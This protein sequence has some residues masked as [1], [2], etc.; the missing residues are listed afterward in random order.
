MSIFT[1]FNIGTGHTQGENNNIMKAL[2]DCCTDPKDRKFIN[3]GPTGLNAGAGTLMKQKLEATWAAFEKA[4]NGPGG[5]K[6]VNLTGHSRG[7]ILCHM[8]A[9]E[10]L[11]KV[12][13]VEVNMFLIDPVN[14][15]FSRHDGVKHLSS[16]PMLKAYHA[17]IM[18]NV[19]SI[20]YPVTLVTADD[21]ETRKKIYYIPMP[22]THGSATQVLTNPIAKVAFELIANFLSK[23]GTSLNHSKKNPAWMC[24]LFAQIH[25]QNPLNAAG[26]RLIF[27]DKGDATRHVAGKASYQ[28][29]DR[30]QEAL[31]EIRQRN[32]KFAG[33]KVKHQH[34]HDIPYFFNQ[35]HAKFFLNAYPEIWAC[36][37]QGR[38]WSRT[39][40]LEII[41]MD[42]YFYTRQTFHLLKP[43]LPI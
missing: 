26:K 2:Y 39:C 38:S 7:A 10:I 4:Y 1:V 16:N 5:V 42:S 11:A 29:I 13:Y 8:I 33:E 41:R 30:R 21:D 32:A 37:A 9:D 3:D 22:G 24:E 28:P 36:I 15:S 17:M 19:N 6:R 35:K 27:D 43:Y 14:M 18:E 34:L 12:P 23:R 20:I 40:D 25:A 31:N